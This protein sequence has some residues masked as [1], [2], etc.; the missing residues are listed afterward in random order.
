[1]ARGKPIQVGP[2]ARLPEGMTWARLAESSP[3][4]VHDKG[5]FPKGFLPLPHPKHEVGGMV[6]PQMVVKLLPRLERF[7]V[8]FDLPEHFLPEFPP[9]IFLTT[10][11]DL[12]DVSQGKM[13]TVENFHELFAGVLN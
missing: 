1:M 10:R 9:A 5:L 13:V 4:E 2:T 7:D 3:A 8:D 11:K 6:F 12:G